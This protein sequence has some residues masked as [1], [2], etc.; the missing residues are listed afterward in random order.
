MMR[1]M[2]R[3]RVCMLILNE[4]IRDG[5]VLRSAK[6]LSKEYD[7]TVLGVDRKKIEFDPNE[8]RKIHGLKM[9]WVK[10]KSSAGLPHNLLGYAA[11]YAEAAARLVIRG[12][13]LR[14]RVVHAHEDSSLPIALAIRSV[15]RAR[16][17][18][19]AHELYR[20]VTDAGQYAWKRWSSRMETWAMRHCSGIIACNSQRAEVMHREYGAPFRPT[21]VRNMP[22]YMKY[23]PTK[24]LRDYLQKKNSAIRYICLHQGGIMPGR[25][26][27][28]ILRALRYLPRDVAMVLIGSGGEKY[29]NELLDEARREG[30]D[31]RF[32]V[33]PAV[34]HA[35]L[36]KMTCSADVGVVIYQNVSRNNYLCAPNKLYEY[37]A[38]GLPIVGAD[39]P[40]IREFLEETGTGGVFDPDDSRS[41]AEA[42]SKITKDT[43]AS[44]RYRKNCLNAARKFCWENEGKV[45]LGLYEKVLA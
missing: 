24:I 31:D 13:A 38:A 36:F 15:T 33:H 22:P 2:A 3:P 23:R 9:E 14:P 20:E 44:E 29:L 39:L 7:L 26:M 21:V 16:I 17:I 8:Q 45:L 43:S 42:I 18:Y 41:L 1:N 35:D 27:E 12:I 30:L 6:T 28:T 25:G 34:D 32:I 10:L 19:D 11:R 40:P 37:A 4:I 5:R